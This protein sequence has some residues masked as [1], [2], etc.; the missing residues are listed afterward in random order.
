MVENV[1]R[2][3]CGYVSCYSAFMDCLSKDKYYVN[4]CT[5]DYYTTPLKSLVLSNFMVLILVLS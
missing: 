2:W 5:S 1:Y 4:I 3:A